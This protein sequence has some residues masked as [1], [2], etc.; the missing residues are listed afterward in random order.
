M[1]H[2]PGSLTLHVLPAL[3]L[4]GL[5]ACNW[6][7]EFGTPEPTDFDFQQIPC[8]PGGQS[9]VLLPEG[10]LAGGVFHPCERPPEGGSPLAFTGWDGLNAVAM[11]GQTTLD[12]D[13]D[14]GA[15]LA[16]SPLLVGVEGERG[17]YLLTLGDLADPAPFAFHVAPDPGRTQFTA[18]LAID[19]GTGTT[20][21]PQVGAILEI[22]FTVLDLGT[23]DVQVTLTWDTHTDVDLHVVDPTGEEIYYGHSESASGGELDHDSNAGCSIDG[24][25]TENVYWPEGGAP[26][27]EYVVRVDYYSA[28]SVADPT[29]YTVVVALHHEDYTTYNGTFLPEDADG[30]GAGSGVTVTT[31]SFP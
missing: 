25:N 6:D 22:P 11:G 14:G 15:S 27:G 16:G 5:V 18:W 23:G 12:L 19:D 28:C 20:D 13:W 4:L 8:E 29:N 1:R 26:A 10:G 3:L 9:S 17:W 2:Q 7:T 30:G 21:E 24:L 31:F